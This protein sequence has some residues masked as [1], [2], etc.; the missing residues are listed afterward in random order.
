MVWWLTY[1]LYAPSAFGA[2]VA[3][4]PR[5][6]STP[7]ISAPDL[8]RH[9]SQAS[10]MWS[11]AD[12]FYHFSDNWQRIT[13]L[14]PAHCF[15]G[16]LA[17]MLDRTSQQEWDH[18]LA[19]LAS[20]NPA[21]RI[22]TATVELRCRLN[23][24]ECQWLELTLVPV[25]SAQECLSVIVSNITQQRLLAEAADIAQR[26][27]A[28][29]RQDR[30]AFLS[31]MSHELRTPLNAILGFAQMMEY[32]GHS[33]EDQMKEYLGHISDSGQD[34]LS[35]INDLLEVATVDAS[36]STLHEDVHNFAD[37]VEAALHMQHHAAHR[38]SIRICLPEH[39]RAA[40]VVKADRPRLIHILCNLLSESIR[41]SEAGSVIQIDWR[42]RASGELALTI[43]DDG[44]GFT[45][46]HLGNIKTALRSKRSYYL[47]DI[48]H[49]SLK[50]ATAREL[51]ALHS[52]E[53]AIDYRPGEG[54]CTTVLLPAARVVEQQV[55]ITS[56]KRKPARVA[57]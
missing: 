55:R 30:S 14:D 6:N 13:E 27:S 33:G 44:S 34:L 29:A 48:D 10:C 52:G 51:L 4:T 23:K 22:D 53:L 16:G 15:S 46:K 35:K 54:A 18:A 19:D 25:R 7:A 9:G 49:I 31:N 57:A 8:S 39:P 24:D 38:R 1:G 42:V 21:E 12:G 50:M 28:I 36:R 47:T 43:E 37:I 32:M 41:R 26:E 20:P 2:E 17:H 11:A 5:P 45:H 40:V 56:K 3:P